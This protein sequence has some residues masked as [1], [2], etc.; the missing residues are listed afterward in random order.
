M[1][2]YF[3]RTTLLECENE[4]WLNRLKL[5]HPFDLSFY[6]TCLHMIG[7]TM[8]YCPKIYF[9]IWKIYLIK[10]KI[11]YINSIAVCIFSY[12]VSNWLYTWTY[13]WIQIITVLTFPACASERLKKAKK[14]LNKLFLILFIN[15]TYWNCAMAVVIKINPWYMVF[16]YTFLFNK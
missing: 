7:S 4:R 8:D 9:F 16:K 5:Q 14:N 10:N 15:F 2:N 11:I 12:I 1:Y 13:F 3:Y 6:R